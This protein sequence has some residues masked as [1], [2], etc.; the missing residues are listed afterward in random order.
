MKF[1]LVNDEPNLREGIKDFLLNAFADLSVDEAMDGNDA[2]R[3][4]SER[5]P[6][7]LV[8]TDVK[9]PGPNGFEMAEMI[10]KQNR[11]QSIGF[12]TGYPVLS[13]SFTPTKIIEYVGKV[14]PEAKLRIV[15]KRARR[16]KTWS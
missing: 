11:K 7:D 10:W 8:L 3:I 6:Y 5:G 15:K 1:L 2:L 16:A 12:M 14:C 4:Y 9:H 13:G